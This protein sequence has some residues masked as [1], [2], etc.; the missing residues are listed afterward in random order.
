MGNKK[1]PAGTVRQK[2]KSIKSIKSMFIRGFLQ[3]FFIVAILLAAGVAGYQL[4]I[5]RW[6]V[7]EQVQEVLQ[8][9]EPT[10]TPISEVRM[11]D[12]S[13]NLIFCYD[14]DTNTIRRLV[15]EVFHREKKQLT[16]LT[17]P[18]NTQLVL[19]DTL[20]KELV[21]YQP[22]MPQMLRLSAVAGYL[23][24]PVIFD[25]V[26]LMVED[27]LELPISYYSVL[28]DALYG[29]I[30][31]E[32]DILPDTTAKM[33]LSPQKPKQ[34]KSGDGKSGVET[35]GQ[36]G[37]VQEAEVFTGEYLKLLKTL[38]D[39]AELE[40][41]MEELYQEMSSNLPLSDK[42]NYLDSYFGISMEDISFTRIAG[43][44]KNSGFAVD[45]IGAIRQLNKL[46]VYSRED[47]GES[48]EEK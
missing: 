19:S 16:Y 42:M 11:D 45:L 15:L 39:E 4:T 48:S 9:P 25:C 8:V 28:P 23:E 20:Y 35:S 21:L 1:R 34:G 43:E 40:A 32:K 5:K 29:T 44:N 33:L 17:I 30:F 47:A 26:V 10:K 22:A 46:E 41:Y 3:S 36:T 31:E 18:M 6:T 27:L 13:K 2:K 24:D 37:E 14:S 7:Q 38:D 12:I